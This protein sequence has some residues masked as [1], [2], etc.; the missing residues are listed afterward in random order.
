MEIVGKGAGQKFARRPAGM[1]QMVPPVDGD[2][3]ERWLVP[4]AFQTSKTISQSTVPFDV[5][6][7]QRCVSALHA[8]ARQGGLVWSTAPVSGSH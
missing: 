1:R 6:Q 2:G 5:I 7:S 3:G 4:S 8:D